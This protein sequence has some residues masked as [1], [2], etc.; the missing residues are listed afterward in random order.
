MK[1]NLYFF[2]C[3]VYYQFSIHT[4]WQHTVQLHFLKFLL[5]VVSSQIYLPISDR[6]SNRNDLHTLLMH[7][8]LW[9]LYH[10]RKKYTH[11]DL[12]FLILSTFLQH[13]SEY[14]LLNPEQLF[15]IPFFSNPPVSFAL[16]CFF[17]LVPLKG[18][19]APLVKGAV[20]PL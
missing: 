4:F 18:K 5:P 12:C 7:L 19:T 3:W 10:F 1:Y 13:S 9:H 6:K 14:I 15:Q 11:T 2:L 16:S 20:E 17:F 8:F